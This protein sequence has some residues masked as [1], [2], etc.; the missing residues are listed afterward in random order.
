M[1]LYVVK[2]AKNISVWEVPLSNLQG[3]LKMDIN[4]FLNRMDSVR[5]TGSNQWISK[6][7]AHEDKSPSLSIKFSDN[8]TI[9]IHCFAGCS[10]NDIVNAID[11]KLSELFPKQNRYQAPIKYRVNYRELWLLA[12]H[13]F[14]ILVIATNDL[15]KN[16][17]L[18]S[19]DLKSVM[20][21]RERINNILGVIDGG[22]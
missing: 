14:W 21:A 10:P 15:E 8:N 4:D 7:P 16:K 9:L 3:A 20:K 2:H 11:S 5:K 18:S 1:N 6:C 19:Y 12:T 13:Y 17:N 22:Y